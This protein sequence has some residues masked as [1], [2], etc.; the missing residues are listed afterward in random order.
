MISGLAPTY[1][2]LTLM[3]A[4]SIAG[5]SPHTEIAIPDD[6]EDDDQDGTYHREHGAAEACEFVKG[7]DFKASGVAFDAAFE[8]RADGTGGRA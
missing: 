5:Y 1:V 2:V 6:P 4:G 7:L 8:K 3:T